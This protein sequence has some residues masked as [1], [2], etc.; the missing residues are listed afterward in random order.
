ML[1]KHQM[2]QYFSRVF[3][4]FLVFVV[5]GVLF[6]PVSAEMNRSMTCGIIL[7]LSGEYE[8]LGNEVLQGIE[9][10]VDQIYGRE[11]E[12][13]YRIALEVRDDRSDPNQSS[14]LFAEMREQGVP[15]V[16]GSVTTSLTLPM[17]EQTQMN[18]TN[19]TVLI[20]P[21]ANGNEIY[22]ISP[23]FY[24]VLPPV[25]YLGTVI[26]DW[27]SYSTTRSALVYTDDSYGRSLRDTI[28]ERLQN[29]STSSKISAE[30]PLI[31]DESGYQLVT[32][33]ILDNVSDAVVLIG[34][35]TE[36]L[37]LLKSLSEAG[38]EGQVVLGESYLMD[39]LGT[40]T[41][42]NLAANFSLVTT[43]AYTTLVP[44]IRTDQFILAYQK[45]YQTS[46]VGTYAGYG[47]D[48]MMIIDEARIH[49]RG[50]GNS[51]GSS[52]MQG[53][54]EIQYYGV[55]GPKVFDDHNA[56]SPV[57]DRFLYR[58]GTFELLSTCIR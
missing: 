26:G 20:S 16:I 50:S 39:L 36:F 43:N 38:Y 14:S 49:E 29:T 31:H 10:A 35:D 23:G 48:S 15:V 13:G 57:Y 41:S 17:A 4:G 54:R 42:G 51:T 5:L 40:D 34:Y 52:L 56:V 7:P 32:S 9:I 47:Y 8:N 1:V 58:N 44:G 37:S 53:L 45:R 33:Q 11:G 28:N 3:F 27:I 12:E 18:T 24:Q 21:L 19:G 22:G 30:I 6:S 55:T 25:F 2:N 46:P